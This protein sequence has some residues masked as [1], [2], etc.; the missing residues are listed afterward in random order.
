M[1]HFL[2]SKINCWPVS[3]LCIRLIFS[4]KLF[5]LLIYDLSMVLLLVFALYFFNELGMLYFNP[6]FLYRVIKVSMGVRAESSSMRRDEGR[7]VR[8]EGGKSFQ[9]ECFLLFLTGQSTINS[10]QLSLCL[11]DSL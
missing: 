8:G 4:S 9:Q 2:K 7:L 6:L 5:Q 11:N 3:W 1:R 10:A